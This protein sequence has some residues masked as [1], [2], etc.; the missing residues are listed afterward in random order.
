MSRISRNQYVSKYFHIM[1]QGINKEKIFLKDEFKEKYLKYTKK[2]MKENNIALLAYCVMINHVHLLIYT[3]D[4]KALSKAM[5]S[6]NTRFAIYYNKQLNRCGYVYRDRYKCQCIWDKNHLENCIRYI[7][8]NPVKAKI[9]KEPKEYKYSSYNG[10]M[11]SK[12]D[13]SVIKLAFGDENNLFNKLNLKENMDNFIDVDLE[14]EENIDNVMKEHAY[15]ELDNP[16]AIYKLICDLKS[17]CN[18][19]NEE[20]ATKLNIKRATFYRL[21]KKFK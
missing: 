8:N 11:N 17:R 5:M 14:K 3:D 16:R 15:E 12:M 2:G 21:L 4:I 20:V 9:C 1:V 18:V 10:Y 13:R 7:H 19:T 6:I